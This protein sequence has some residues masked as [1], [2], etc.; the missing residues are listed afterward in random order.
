MLVYE[1]LLLEG[2]RVGMGMTL[3]HT[4]TSC[5]RS[6]FVGVG[7]VWLAFLGSDTMAFDV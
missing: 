6:F 3:S 4:R 7:I 5:A 2:T 1:Y